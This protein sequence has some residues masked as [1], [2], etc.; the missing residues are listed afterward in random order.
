VTEAIKQEIKMF[1]EFNEN[2]NTH[3][4]QWDRAKATLRGKFMAI[5]AFKKQRSFK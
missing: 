4:H 1:L 2:E 5:S 3:Y